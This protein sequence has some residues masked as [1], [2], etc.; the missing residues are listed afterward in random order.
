M[1]LPRVTARLTDRPAQTPIIPDPSRHF[2][3]IAAAGPIM[4]VMASPASAE[5]GRN[6]SKA[7]WLTDI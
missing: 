6:T 2:A 7:A 3:G 1:Q 5:H 4:I